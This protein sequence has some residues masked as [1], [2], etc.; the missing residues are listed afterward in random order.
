MNNWTAENISKLLADWQRSD[1]VRGT[2]KAM[3]VED[4]ETQLCA[5][6]IGG[7]YCQNEAEPFSCYCA[8]CEREIG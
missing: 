1:L 6:K 3:A 5:R 7:E 8:E 2:R 4:Y